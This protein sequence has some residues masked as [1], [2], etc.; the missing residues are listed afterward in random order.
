MSYVARKE[1][2]GIPTTIVDTCLP[3]CPIWGTT[4]RTIQTNA[5]LCEP[6]GA[7]LTSTERTSTLASGYASQH[8]AIDD[9]IAGNSATLE[10]RGKER[11]FV[12]ARTTAICWAARVCVQ[13]E[14]LFGE[15]FHRLRALSGFRV[16]MM[17][18]A[19][20]RDGSVCRHTHRRLGKNI[21]SLSDASV[22]GG[23]GP[24]GT[25]VDDR[26]AARGH[27]CFGAHAGQ[28]MKR[29]NPCHGNTRQRRLTRRWCRCA[30]GKWKFNRCALDPDQVVSIWTLIR[31]N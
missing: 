26:G 21:G 30:N 18:F 10:T 2:T 25:N 27:Y 12:F 17:E 16:P 29:T 1:I 28:G 11:N 4:I 14:L 3:R 19:S 7:A 13:N 23:R 8:Q 6:A 20:R 31:M 5:S 15:W 24:S 9:R 22:S